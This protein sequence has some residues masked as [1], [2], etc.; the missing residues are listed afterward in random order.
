MVAENIKIKKVLIANRGEIACRAIKTCKKLGIK[1]VSVYSEVDYN[2]L[3]ALQ[4]DEAFLIGPAPSNQ[5]YLVIDKIIAAVK[6]SG[7]DAVYP[8]YGFLSENTTF[9]KALEDNG[10]VFIGPN[11]K[12]IEAMG[13]KI[14][15]KRTAIAAGVS[16]VP[17]FDGVIKDENH[18]AEVSRSIGFPVILKASAGGGGKGIRIVYDEKEIGISFTS[19]QNE[20][21]KSFGDDRIF[22]EKFIEKPR[23][24]EIQVLADK[25]GNV[26]C[27][28]ERE[29]SIQRNNQKVI[30]EAPSSF[31]TPEVRAKMYE[32][33]VMLAKKVGYDSAG[34][35]EYI[36]DQNRNFYFLEMNTRLQVEHPVTEYITGFDMIEQMLRVADGQKLQHKQED[37]KLSGW[38]F[39]ARVCSEDASKNFLPSTGWLSTYKEPIKNENVR[40]DTGVKEGCFIT[41]FYDPMIAKLITYGK[42]RDEARQRLIDS[43]GQFAIEGVVTNIPIVEKILLDPDFASGN[44]STNFIKQKGEALNNPKI[45][46]EEYLPIFI[47]A[48]VFVSAERS[49]QS[50]FHS[51]IIP[52]KHCV[53]LNGQ[54]YEATTESLDDETLVLTIG[55]KVYKISAASELSL[56]SKTI[57]L[58]INDK[59]Y[60]FRLKCKGSKQTIAAFGSVVD[61]ISFDAKFEKFIDYFANNLG[62]ASKISELEAPISGLVTAIHVKDGDM[63]NPGD[64]L[65]TIEAMKMENLITAEFATKIKKINCKA[66]DA[67]SVGDFVIDFDNSAN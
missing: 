23:H 6:Q 25:H 21:R 35:I 49:L 20:A 10:I 15:S 37:V 14:E 50:S 67:V 55:G 26:I 36:V 52:S 28:G 33:S 3:P 57:S 18:A 13:D 45:I 30:E 54:K 61:F 47:S 64:K 22:I 4:A 66:G 11:S 56:A 46:L 9:A 31:I 58:N 7:A 8:G 29:C 43:L 62:S 38:A 40:V 41:Q 53:M 44:I 2:F 60:N 59:I 17:G 63:V 51:C 5:S 1:T 19:V 12:A 34:T 27:L 48:A 24:I 42:T 65:L 16:V 32:Q 39:E